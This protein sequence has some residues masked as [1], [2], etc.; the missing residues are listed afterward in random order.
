MRIAVVQGTRPEIIKNYSIVKALRSAGVHSEVLHTNQHS[1]NCMSKCIYDEMSYAPDRTLPGAY[2][3]GGAVV[4]L[5]RVLRRDKIDHVIVNGDTASGLAGA[6]AAL[7]AD[8]DVSHVEAGLRSG[9]KQMREERNRIIVDSTASV[10]FAYTEY[11]RYV[12]ESERHRRGRIFVEG[13][14]TV[15]VLHD[16][17]SSPLLRRPPV[18]G[19]YVYVTLHRKE[20]TDSC[21][22][23]A[24]VFGALR[25]ISE[26]MCAVVF[27]MHP[28]TRHAARRFGLGRQALGAVQVIDPVS[29][30]ASL[31]L[32][33]HA[34]AVVTDS[35]CIQEEAYLLHVPCVTVR[36]NTERHMTVQN[37][38][39]VLAGFEPQRIQSAVKWAAQLTGRTWPPI[40]GL[41]GVADRI[42]HRIR[43]GSVDGSDYGYDKALRP[44]VTA[45]D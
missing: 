9:D 36:N 21:V 34:A 12:L 33:K 8:I 41:P 29:P 6:L 23:M 32:E 20:F 42:V 13:N 22:R 4:W 40:Y 5:E 31:S 39:N 38:A 3:F 28:R 45:A 17:A 37:G 30:M 43:A 26:G 11:E 16:F 14:T 15:D 19:S 24:Q 1:I 25:R 7:Y 27:A 2:T 10:L 18:S 35:G 44:V